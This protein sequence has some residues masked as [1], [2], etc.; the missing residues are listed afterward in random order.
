MAPEYGKDYPTAFLNR[1]WSKK[2][3]LLLIFVITR[4]KVINDLRANKNGP[5]KPVVLTGG[6]D[7]GVSVEK[8][9]IIDAV[10]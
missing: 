10:S 4:G 7:F 3:I 1:K 8:R 6:A 5:K 2:T 9:Q